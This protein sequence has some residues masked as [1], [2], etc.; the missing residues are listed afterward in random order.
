[1]TSLAMRGGK[2]SKFRLVN[3]DWGVM[4]VL[5]VWKEGKKKNARL[6]FMVKASGNSIF[7]KGKHLIYQEPKTGFNGLPSSRL[8]TIEEDSLKVKT[9]THMKCW[10]TNYYKVDMSPEEMEAAFVDMVKSYVSSD[11]L[12]HVGG[13][14]HRRYTDLNPQPVMLADENGNKVC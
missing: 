9:P 1:M 4:E 7:Q 13:C 10:T 3:P 8:E 14:V 6:T 11:P 2:M 5:S 12:V